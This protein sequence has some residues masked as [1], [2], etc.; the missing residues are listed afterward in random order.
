M[1][2]F[3]EAANGL[4]FSLVPH[5]HPSKDAF[6]RFTPVFPFSM[7]ILA[8][9]FRHPFFSLLILPHPSEE[10]EGHIASPFI[11]LYPHVYFCPS[12][13]RSFPPGWTFTRMRP[14][15]LYFI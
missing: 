8:R 4:N 5:C 3:N 6:F 15:P 11:S 14:F 7:S 9:N 1:A 2:F 10:S 12:F 13:L